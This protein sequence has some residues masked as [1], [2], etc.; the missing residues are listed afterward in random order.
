MRG[1]QLVQIMVKLRVQI[2]QYVDDSQ[3]GWV[4]A[5]LRDA[6]GNEWIFV[7]KVPIFTV[8]SLDAHSNYPQPGV[9]R[10]EIIRLWRDV[11]GREL[12]T[13]DTSRPDFVE[14]TNGMSRFNVLMEQLVQS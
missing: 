9:I 10:C 7:D 14:A 13:I 11:G 6:W 8:T 2:V 1:A 12:C 5:N 4:E 3:P